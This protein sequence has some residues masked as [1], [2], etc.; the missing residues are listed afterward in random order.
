MPTVAAMNTA[1]FEKLPPALR[2]GAAKDEWD[3][4]VW[5]LRHSFRSAEQL[6]RVLHLSDDEQRA[7]RTA[8]QRL[9]I[10]ITPHFLSLIDPDDPDDPLRL[11]VIP[12]SAELTRNPEELTDPCGEEKDV[13]AP[14]LVH[15]YPDRVLLLCT[16]RCSSYCRYCTRS[17]LVSGTGGCRLHTDLDAA[18]AY[19]RE[20]REVR[21]V[22]LS[23]GDPLLLPDAR[24]DAILTRLRAIPHLELLRIGT[25]VPIMLPQRITPQ[26]CAMLRRHS[27]LFISVHCNH[28]RE[29]CAD[30]E[31]A[32]GLLV[33]HGLPVG[34][35]SVLLRGVN[36]SLSTQLSL[37]HRLLQCRVKPYYLY[38][39]DL[40][41][42][43]RHFRTD[44]RDGLKLI[45]GM[46]GHTSGYGVPLYVVDAPGG[47]GKIPLNP[48]TIVQQDAQGFRLVNYRGRY[49]HYPI[50]PRN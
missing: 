25:R 17:R 23:G 45:A 14:G 46:R 5:Q 9:A 26:L 39:C 44:I 19:L 12:R 43:T 40:A 4:A 31:H 33:D 29:L 49:Y 21:D 7:L 28:P 38:Q 41:P 15:R 47:G 13:V 27:P 8:G 50:V 6:S 18:L 32:L 34:S 16:D 22:L 30:A 10:R 11:Q 36:D 2:Q 1:E 3:T 24:I 20:H 42:G 48:D 35:Q 37:S